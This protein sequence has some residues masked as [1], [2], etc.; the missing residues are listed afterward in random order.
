[1]TLPRLGLPHLG[2]GVGLRSAHFDHVLER[3][4]PVDWFE[5]IS[6]NF[7]NSGGR[8][9][10]VLEKVAARYPIV[11]HGVSLS[12]GSADPL[13]REY[14]ARLKQFIGEIDAVW[15]SDHV[16]WTGIAGLN[17][18]EL[19]PIPFTEEALEHVVARI[20]IVQEILERQ[21]VLE[22]PSSYVTYV[23]S[24]LTEWE[25]LAR[26][27]QDA[28]CGLLL[29]VA[30][31]RV[32]A[33]NHEFDPV[34]YLNAL[35]HERIVQMHLAGHTENATHIVDTHDRAVSDRVWE[36]YGVASELTG[37]VSTL[38]EWDERLPSFPELHAET[39]KAK[40]Y[41]ARDVAPPQ[42]IR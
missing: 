15:V 32:S 12:I 2:Y 19:I 7:M 4:P 34:E 18:H 11:A 37:G 13:D 28:D 33:V 27:A 8:A 6:E 31:V 42:G 21:I 9:R 16:C 26:M 14:L 35:P 24:T 29:D 1:V 41:L 40:R 3:C 17:T 20:R 25:F 36:L 10:Y 30:N 39:L 23:A 22:N 5:V 38:I